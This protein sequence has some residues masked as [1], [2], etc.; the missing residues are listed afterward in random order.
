MTEICL[1]YLVVFIIGAVF[2][3]R[4][5]K[6]RFTNLFAIALADLDK[7]LNGSV[8]AYIESREKS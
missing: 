8:I 6:W 7:N 5:A 3:Y 1:A 4:Y 2:G